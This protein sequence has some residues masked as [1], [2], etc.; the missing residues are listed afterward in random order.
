LWDDLTAGGALAVSDGIDV[1]KPIPIS[2][3]RNTDPLMGKEKPRSED[4]GAGL[5]GIPIS[6]I[7][8]CS[9]LERRPAA[10]P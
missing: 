4:G 10:R 2:A 7:P 5:A 6:I 9:P 3:S 1:S 8:R